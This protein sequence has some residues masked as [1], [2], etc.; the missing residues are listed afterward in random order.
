MVL[1]FAFQNLLS[2]SPPLSWPLWGP[3]TCGYSSTPTPSTGMGPL[4]RGRWNT[5]LPVGA[6]MTGSRWTPQTTRSGT[7]TRTPSTRS[8]CSSPGRARAAPGLPALRSGPGPSV[9]VSLGPWGL[10]SLSYGLEVCG[11]CESQVVHTP[12][13]D[14]RRKHP[15]QRRGPHSPRLQD[16]KAWCLSGSLHPFFLF[17]PPLSI[18][19]SMLE[20]SPRG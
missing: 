16:L 2:P 17:F 3:P 12:P 8:A 13:S 7:W 9:L 5:A 19:Q 18:S 1:W 15:F 6:G 4:W 10:W 11:L 20:T 14:L